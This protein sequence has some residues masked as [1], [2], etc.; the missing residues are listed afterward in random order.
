VQEQREGHPE[1]DIDDK[2]AQAD[3]N[4]YQD[5]TPGPGEGVAIDDGVLGP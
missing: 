2:G 3:A 5:G 1:D 4:L